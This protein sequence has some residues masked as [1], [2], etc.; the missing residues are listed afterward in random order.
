MKKISLS[1]TEP[2]LWHFLVSLTGLVALYQ[3]YL[4]AWKEVATALL[5]LSMF[6]FFA[7]YSKFKSVR[8]PLPLRFLAIGLCLVSIVFGGLEQKWETVG[9]AVIAVLIFLWPLRL[10]RKRRMKIPS[11]F[12]V[13]IFIYIVVSMLLGEVFHF[14]YHYRWWDVIAHF[15]SAP[16][17]GYA[18]FVLVYTLNRDKYIH[19]RLS[20]FFIAFFALS[21]SMLVGVAWEIFEYLADA[22]TGAN[23]QKAR[24]LELVYGYF[25]TRLGVLDTME[26]MIVN[27]LGA[28][29]VSFLGYRYLKKRSKDVHGFWSGIDQFFH[30][31]PEFFEKDKSV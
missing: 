4:Q 1:K 28:S 13:I 20:P 26:D 15:S 21:F 18:G 12:Q 22:I 14:Y 2:I 25:D 11:L 24:D 10:Q 7:M 19:R 30:D 27:F 6:V 16:F 23:M 17:I 3:L 5:T 31:N 8:F 9:I 29:I